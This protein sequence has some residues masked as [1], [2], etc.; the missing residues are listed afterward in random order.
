MSHSRSYDK[1]APADTEKVGLGA[2][3][4]RRVKNDVKERLAVDHYFDGE[5]NNALSAC[6]GRHE[7]VRFNAISDP[8]AMSGAGIIYTKESPNKVLNYRDASGSVVNLVNNG[9]IVKS[10]GQLAGGCTFSASKSTATAAG[11]IIFNN[12]ILDSLSCYGSGTGIFTAPSTGVYV[13]AICGSFLMSSYDETYTIAF[14]AKR[15]G[16][17]IATREKKFE[18][19]PRW[20]SMPALP[21]WTQKYQAALYLDLASG[22]EVTF[23]TSFGIDSDATIYGVRAI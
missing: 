19:Y 13:F 15:S 14:S 6:E 1:T 9:I 17:V 20:G 10:A 3:E 23:Y 21:G 12:V 22:D 18:R 16:V 11:I 5:L 7:A 2:A 8:T 4:I